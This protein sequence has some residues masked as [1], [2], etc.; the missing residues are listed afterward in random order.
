MRSQVAICDAF[1][2]KYAG[3]GTWQWTRQSARMFFDDA[4]GIATDAP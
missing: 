4:T 2:V 3:D 1:L